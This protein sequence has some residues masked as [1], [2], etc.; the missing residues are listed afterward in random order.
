MQH[1]TIQLRS[2][3]LSVSQNS[4]MQRCK[5]GDRRN[6]R[7]LE[8]KKTNT[9][10]E[11]RKSNR[12]TQQNTREHNTRKSEATGLA[13]QA[14]VTWVTWCHA[15]AIALHRKRIIIVFIVIVFIVI[16][17]SSLLSFNHGHCHY[18][19]HASHFSALFM[20]LLENLRLLPFLPTL[21]LIVA[22]A[23]CKLAFEFVNKLF[24]VA[25]RL[26]TLGLGF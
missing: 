15:G 3:L 10:L 4:T 22:L 6:S 14:S 18:C 2:A 24:I 9:T 11:N 26:T 20:K 23:V 13:A 5:T 7:T 25:L 12:T 21:L 1:Y 8:N 19:R 17:A 16:I